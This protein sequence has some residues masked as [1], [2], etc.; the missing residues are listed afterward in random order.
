MVDSYSLKVGDEANKGGFWDILDR[1]RDLLK[2]T[3]EDP[4]GEIPSEEIGKKKL[5]ALLASGAPDEAGLVQSAVEEFAQEVARVIRKLLRLKEWQDTECVVI[6]GGFQAS[7]VGKLAVGR[8]ALLLKAEGIDVDLELIRHD[9][10]HAGLVGAAHLLPSWML[11]GHDAILALD[12]GGTNIRAGVVE[13]NLKKSATLADATVAKL[14][15][16]R[17]ADEKTTRDKMADRIAT[18][19]EKLRNSCEKN[20]IGLAPVVGIGCIGTIEEDGSISAGA[21]N[22]PGNWESSRFNL[23][24]VIREH[25]PK[26]GNHE[27]IVI[28]HNDAVV[29]GLSALP[30]VQRRIHWGILTI[31]T[32]LGNAHF[33]NRHAAKRRLKTGAAP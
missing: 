6:G 2:E 24:N 3:D 20:K 25:V 1:W 16:W 26:V 30:Y 33:T 19:L 4:L 10:N 9:P 7:R 22:L 23:P 28:M 27:T 8:T 12:V 13:L 15:H 21:A 29:Q 17:H 5:A 31:G 14:E 32:G 11:K 18:M